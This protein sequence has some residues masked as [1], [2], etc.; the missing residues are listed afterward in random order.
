MVE[1]LCI[2]Q[3][4]VNS[5]RLPA[6]VM[7][8]LAGKTLL[9]RVYETVSKSKKISK[10]IVATSTKNTDDII[11]KKL[12]QL[13]I[14]YYRGDLNNVLKRFY[15]TASYYKAKNIVRITADNPLMDGKV[16]DN[17]I[18]LY[19]NNSVEYSSYKNELYGLSAEL[20]SFEALQKAYQNATNQYDKEHV[21]PYIINNCK[22]YIK[23]IE[24]K[25]RYP[26]IRVTI[27][28]LEDYINI[29]NFYLYCQTNNYI[30]NIDNFLLWIKN[31]K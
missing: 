6:K 7:L 26:N 20:F 22:T 24:E 3:A 25:Y 10:L 11:V 13:N 31:V 23:D 28:T 30:S 14:E 17:L 12:E 9:Q 29:Q 19:E 4:R 27:D 16:I 1:Y 15:D 8:D 2:I 5:T 18:E 21:T